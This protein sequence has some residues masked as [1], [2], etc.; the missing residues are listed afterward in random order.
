[1]EG[2][3]HSCSWTTYVCCEMQVIIAN[4]P[5]Q[6][7]RITCSLVAPLIRNEGHHI[8][9]IDIH[10][11]LGAVR[12]LENPQCITSPREVRTQ[13][14]ETNVVRQ[15]T[16]SA[17]LHILDCDITRGPS[18]PSALGWRAPFTM[19]GCLSKSGPFGFP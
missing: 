9:K 2:R 14:R 4:L 1:M 18:K 10:N 16:S 19:W 3:S 15:Y 5:K 8:P 7:K 13:S 11:R 17:L 12:L 6:N